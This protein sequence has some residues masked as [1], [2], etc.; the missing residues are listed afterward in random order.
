LAVGARSGVQ[1]GFLFEVHLPVQDVHA[2]HAEFDSRESMTFSTGTIGGSKMPVRVC[3]NAKL[4]FCSRRRLCR[5]C[6]VR[7]IEPPAARA[8]AARKVRREYWFIGC[9]CL[10]CHRCNNPAR[11]RGQA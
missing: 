5:F 3:R 8:V 6:V 11:Q 4:Y 2:R 7:I 10:L 9:K 1:R